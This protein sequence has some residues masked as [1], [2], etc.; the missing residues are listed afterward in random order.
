MV[1][2]VVDKYPTINFVDIPSHARVKD[3]WRNGCWRLPDPVD[4]LTQRTWEE[5]KTYS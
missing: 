4:D 3:L 2:V 5:I 1:R